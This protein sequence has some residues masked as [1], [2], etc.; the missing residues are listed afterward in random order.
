M[1]LRRFWW[2]DPT[3]L[4]LA[5]ARLKK[6][7]ETQA[8]DWDWIT[9]HEDDHPGEEEAFLSL[10]S[11][12]GIPPMFGPGKVVCCWDLPSFH[13]KLAGELEKIP[14][15]IMLIL[16]SR[17]QKNLRLYKKAEAIKKATPEAVELDEAFALSKDNAPEFVIQRAKRLGLDITR[18]HAKVLLDFVGLDAAQLTTELKKIRNFSDERVVTPWIIEQTC[19][20]DGDATSIEFSKAVM[21]RRQDVAHEYMRR[22]LAK[23]HPLQI[24]AYLASWARTLLVV[25]SRDGDYNASKAEI[26]GV[27]TLSKDKS[28]LIP[29]W[30]NPGRLYYASKE[31]AKGGFHPEWPMLLLSEAWR[32]Q[33]IVRKNSTNKDLIEKEFHGFVFRVM[34]QQDEVTSFATDYWGGL[35]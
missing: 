4:A 35:T 20:G 23:D 10:A 22:I 28:K 14:D 8:A 21:A 3:D 6:I 19:Y 1:A 11:E 17:P 16:V 18:G 24:C 2:L 29:M 15:R 31:L 34:A 33:M 5:K 7:R 32:I 13:S 9:W 27:K 26:A 25:N 30:P 12:I